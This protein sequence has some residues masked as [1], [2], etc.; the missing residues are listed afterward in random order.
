MGASVVATYAI[1]N[2]VFKTEATPVMLGLAALVGL[3]PDL[4]GIVAMMAKRERPMQQKVQ[5]HWYVTHTPLFYLVLTLLLSLVAPAETSIL[6]G[7]L[8]LTHLVLDSW[9]TDDGIMWLWPLSRKQYALFPHDLHE[10]GVFGLDFYLRVLRCKPMI[11]PELLFAFFGLALT[12]H[13]VA[14][15]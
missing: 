9:A 11:V 10:G 3:L 7:M 6:F 13:A 8:M 14:G 5:H 15:I 12:A 2:Y 4:D 1:T